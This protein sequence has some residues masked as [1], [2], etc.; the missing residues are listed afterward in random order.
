MS[1]L[2]SEIE[3]IENKG[4]NGTGNGAGS[5]AGSGTS[6]KTA[7]MYFAAGIVIALVALIVLS[8]LWSPGSTGSVKVIR[9][10][11]EIYSGNSPNGANSE[12]IGSLIRNAADDPLVE[13]IVLRIDSQGGVMAA[14]E[15]IIADVEYAKTKK[16][17]ITSMGAQATSAAYHISSHTDRIFASPDTATAGIG[18]I[19][20]FYDK[21]R[22]YD[23]E[24]V[25]VEPIKSVETKDAG[26]DY[27][28]LSSTERKYM[29]SSVDASGEY[30]INDILAQ[31]PDVSRSDI[32]T[33]R[34]IRGAEALELGLI[35]EI[36]NLYQ[37]ID[38][39][40]NYKNNMKND[41]KKGAKEDADKTDEVKEED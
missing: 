32:E 14:G 23:R 12:Y 29:Q 10:E 27:R 13:A 7:A 1:W 33:G 22:V 40:K 4:S 39:A 18:V 21:S 19:I 24:G 9:I 16:P 35:D 8:L 41:D 26:A 2:E 36:G 15:E 11:G 17:V 30:F 38:Y 34:I 3:K 37:A 6:K 20:T 5:G 28:G 31:R 25:V